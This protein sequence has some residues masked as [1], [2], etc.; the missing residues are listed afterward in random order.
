MIN[1]AAIYPATYYHRPSPCRLQL[2]WLVY[3][4]EYIT[5]LCYGLAI[6]NPMLTIL[7]Q[8]G[9]EP[10]LRFLQLVAIA[11]FI[12]ITVTDVTTP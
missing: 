12:I 10:L 5:T 9:V 3:D 11:R 4:P 6:Y 7:V 2:G 1:S 8:H